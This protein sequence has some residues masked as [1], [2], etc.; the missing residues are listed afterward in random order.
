[1]APTYP[2]PTSTVSPRYRRAQHLR[3]HA[4]LGGLG[5]LRGHARHWGGGAL[6]LW[7]MPWD[8]WSQSEEVGRSMAI[9]I[10]YTL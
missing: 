2:P 5:A 1:M 4:A 8:F 10:D 7:R 9:S 6:Q 3:L